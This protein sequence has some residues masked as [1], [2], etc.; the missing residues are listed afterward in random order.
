MRQDATLDNLH[1]PP[2]IVTTPLDALSE[3]RRGGIG[4]RQVLLISGLGFGDSIWTEFMARHAERFTMHAVTLP[5]FGG[6]PPYPIP[7][8]TAGFAS[9]PW[10]RSTARGVQ[11]YLDSQRIDRVTIIGHWAGATQL[12]LMLALDHPE[13]VDAVVLIGGSLK[14]VFSAVPG[15]DRWSPAQRAAQTDQLAR[16][17]FRTVTRATWDDN[18][19][20]PWDYAV[21]PLRG[22]FLWRQAQTPT[23]PV[24]VRYLMEFYAV[25][26]EPRLSSL[27]VPVLVVEPG[28]DDPAYVAEPGRDYMRDLTQ[29]SWQTA[30]AATPN[31]RFV[32][33]P[34]SRLFVMYDQPGALDAALADFLRGQP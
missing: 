17:W 21:N 12:A 22:L 2:G 7:P 16:Q 13:R 14:S 3:V 5:G 30:R 31:L 25:D 27:R 19:F 6:T 10:L 24:W 23:L 32:T 4:P 15:M 28:F 1:H 18:N 33:I 26:V 34:G 9:A 29:R 11:S 20:M 8:D